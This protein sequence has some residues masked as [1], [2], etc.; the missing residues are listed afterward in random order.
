MAPRTASPTPSASGRGMGRTD[1]PTTSM[2][3]QERPVEVRLPLPETYDGSRT[4][5]KAFLMQAELY[6]G[7]NG[8]MFSIEPQ[9]VLWAASFM[10]GRA[11]EWIQT[12]TNDHLANLGITGP[13]GKV[14]QEDTR[15]SETQI[16]FHT[17][18]NFKVKINR[19]FGDIDEERTA[20]R[21]MQYLRQKGAATAYAA[22]FQQYSFRTSWN[23]DALMAEFYKGLKDS[24]K[25][26]MARMENRGKTLQQMITVAIRIDNRL[27]ERSLERKGQY[28]PGHA[29]KSQPQQRSRWPEAMEIDS[30]RQQGPRLPKEELER[31]RKNRLC[32]ECGKEGHMA[33]FHRQGQKKPPFGKGKGRPQ[34]KRLH[35]AMQINMTNSEEWHSP[36]EE[37]W[38]DGAE[39][40]DDWEELE[41]DKSD[42]EARDLTASEERR[43]T[44]IVRQEE[45]VLIRNKKRHLDTTVQVR[46]PANDATHPDH[47]LHGTLTY[48]ACAT[49][50][51]RYHWEEKNRMSYHPSSVKP[52]WM[53]ATVTRE[54]ALHVDTST[55]GPSSKEPEPVA[56]P[57]RKEVWD[58]E[59]ARLLEGKVGEPWDAPL[60]YPKVGEKYKVFYIF[61][62]DGTRMMLRTVPDIPGQYIT[63][64]GWK[65]G[66]GP[67]KGDELEVFYISAHRTGWKKTEGLTWTPYQEIC[68]TVGSRQQLRCD[69]IINGEKL[70]AM[71]DSGATGNFMCTETAKWDGVW[72]QKKRKPYRLG[73]IDGSHTSSEAGWVTMETQSLQMTLGDHEEWIKFD[74]TY[75][76]TH[77]VV[78]GMPWLVTHNPRIDWRTKE[79]I[80]AD[81]D[82]LSPTPPHF[83]RGDASL[84]Q[85]EACATSQDPEDP[86]RAS[87][88]DKIPVQYREEFAELFVETLDESA[89]PAHQPWD[90][91]IPIEE[92]K[93]PPFGP[94]YQMSETELAVLKEYIDKNLKKGYI[95][96]ST[97]RAGAPVLFVPK[98][99]KELRLVVDYRGLNNVTIKDRYSTPL[100]N[101]LNDRLK[102]AIWFTKLDQKGGYD[103]IRMKEG[104]EWKTAFRTR[105]GLYEYQIMPQGLTNAPATHMRWVNNMLREHLDVF[106]IA[107]LDDVL[108]Y[109][110]S[111]E[112]HRKHVW[113][114]LSIF[115]ENNVRLAPA[116]ADWC[117][118][119]VEFLG[120]MVGADGVR[121]SEDK[122]R[123]VLEW[124]TPTNVKEIQAFIGFSNF[125]RRFIKHFSAVALPLTAKTKRQDELFTWGN[126]TQEAFDKLKQHFTE[127]PILATHDPEKDMVLETDA[128]DGAIGGCLSQRGDD[129]LLHPLAYYSRKLTGAELNYDVH[130]KELLAIIDTMEHW[131]CYLEGSKNPVQVWT[132]HKNLI[133]F[134]TTKK[135][136]RRQVRWSETLAKYNFKIT[137]R[138]GT[139]NARADALSRRSDFMGKTDRKETLL[140]EGD[141]GLEYSGEIATIFEVVEDPTI[142]Q[143]IKDAY[144]GDAGARRAKQ[145]KR[146]ANGGKPTFAPDET[147]LIRFRG[148]VYLPERIRK[149]FTKEL[150][151]E[152]T[153]GHLGIEKTRDAVA[154]RY[155]FPSIKRVVER[156][157]RECDMCQKAKVSRKHPYGL[158]KSPDTPSEPWASIAMDF[159]V[160]LPPSEEP[161][162]NTVFDSIWVI[163]DRL[164]KAVHFIPYKE[165]SNAQEMAYAFSKEVVKRHGLPEEIITDRDKLFTSKYWTSLM[166]QWGVNHKLSTAYHPQT[167]GQTERMNQTLEQYLRSYV[168][169]AQDNWVALLPTAEFAVNSAT[170][171]TTGVTPFYANKGYQPVMHRKLRPT[172]AVSQAASLEIEKLKALHGQLQADIQFLNERSAVYAN[173]H[174]S[175]EPPWKEGD[176]VYLLRKNIKTKRPSS[177]LDF[178][179][180]GPYEIMEKVSDVNF[181]LRLPKG[182]R[183]HPVFHV[184]L[185]SEAPPDAKTNDEEIQ[186]AEEPDVYDVEKILA[187]RVSNGKIEYLIK[188]LDWDDIH[189]TWEPQGHLRCP[190]KV[191]GFHRENPTEPTPPEKVGELRRPQRGRPL[192]T[193]E[194]E[195]WKA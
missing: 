3:I 53:T 147:G 84:G 24:V 180:L 125:Y 111:F 37:P 174:R 178:K 106:V 127:A 12:F 161:M 99:D 119:E 168:N 155:Y 195:H 137:Y 135:L 43:I 120:V 190:E 45:G 116:K 10:R 56:L 167:D 46:D 29:R 42:E 185:L 171:S 139:E 58:K 159:I 145:Q 22:E 114:I 40:S 89:L 83:E 54:G 28:T 36:D 16:L 92:G 103:H 52:V 115:K 193:T 118:K 8:H 78:L 188:W 134:T 101:E 177:K 117:K 107:Y 17:W 41:K 128:S 63:R 176:K 131:R 182:S 47:P 95:R 194:P 75:L 73:L 109:S 27:Y 25:D 163:V 14:I 97:S 153:T 64:S 130:D 151:E 35:A 152:P 181:R 67:E 129:E 61:P 141:G 189:N 68:A 169:H 50:H 192:S 76:G 23:D 30:A 96:E 80:F 162:T 191:V 51:C 122:V 186:P 121:M 102:G 77:E 143:R 38:I 165:G 44:E 13:D 132:D 5:L 74:V 72:T 7:F 154:A 49:E 20:E 93:T 113:T 82:H 187:S 184:S 172:S 71:I 140:K 48:R 21:A 81:C 69:V 32:F 126:Q 66:H 85:E 138:K 31:R 104:E 57:P 65:E 100:P 160:K 18:N 173:K 87:L 148:V 158:L 33:S 34:N 144:P 1:T 133:Y 6:I 183:I 94:I 164:T 91:E 19:M 55:S 179:K 170:A 88:L 11:F 123:A 62:S 4:K 156:V 142:E 175:Q 150:H 90:H 157:V 79:L 70:P 59:V 124:P 98:K 110:K 112:E 166:A 15:D 60:T 105:Y 2:T 26:E 149:E 9:K 136:N 39:Y 146:E 86:P 108:I